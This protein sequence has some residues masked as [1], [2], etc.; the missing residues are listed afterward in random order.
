MW[1]GHV[2]LIRAGPHS[3]YLDKNDVWPV[4][5]TRYWASPKERELEKQEIT[6]MPPMDFIERNKSVWG[7]S[8]FFVLKNDG[9]FPFCL[10][11][12]KL[13]T[14]TIRHT[15][16]MNGMDECIDSFQDVSIDVLDIGW[17]YGI[18]ESQDCRG[19]LGKCFISVSLL[20]LLI[21]LCRFWIGECT[22]D[23]PWSNG[24]PIEES[25]VEISIFNL[26]DLV[27]FLRTLGR[28]I[29]NVRQ[30]LTLW[31]E[32]DVIFSLMK[33]RS[34]SIE[35]IIPAMSF[36]LGASNFLQKLWTPYAD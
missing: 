16:R 10:T 28:H 22:R 26:D 17:W 1:D 36:K 15:Y 11:S 32:A 8:D 30:I 24:R 4:Y 33:C 29:D 14:L 35:L 20:T 31:N 5:S 3:I 6:R 19:R 2:V 21:Y 13:N 25:R 34:F 12:H 23:M 18:L 7:S 27:K 9:D